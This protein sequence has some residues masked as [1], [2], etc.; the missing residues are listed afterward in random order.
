MNR[1]K[2]NLTCHS[3]SKIF[4]DPVELPCKHSICQEHFSEKKHIK[5]KKIKCGACK[6][7]FEIKEF[8][9]VKLIKNLLDI[10][11]Y[12]N[13]D[14]FKLKNQIIDSFENCN[15][16]HDEFKHNKN[17]FYVDFHSHFQEIKRQIDFQGAKLKE[18]IDEATLELIKKAEQFEYS[19]LQDLNSNNVDFINSTEKISL[20]KGLKEIE[21]KFRN[22]N[23][24]IDSMEKILFDQQKSTIELK[25][26]I[27]EMNLLKD[28]LI[29]TNHFK[30]KLIFNEELLGSLSLNQVPYGAFKSRILNVNM[31]NDLIRLCEFMPKDHW[32][33]LYRA[34][35]DG[36]G[37]KDFHSK[38]DNHT[39]TLTII[40]EKI[41][42]LFLE[43]ILQPP[44]I[45]LINTS[46]TLMPFYLV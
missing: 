32:S 12:L 19:Y 22:S 27:N 24:S 44:G 23:I 2:S 4:K 8:R 10:Q 20:E 5:D 34:S 30:P 38:C 15:K 11:I 28:I 31:E 13:D 45:A 39:N 41:S 43:L 14:E 33:L 36:F 18:K 46:Q 26:K 25:S 7:Y 17:S 21:E 6:E 40:K 35:R 9:I 1:W 3:C 16:V 37:S 29:K 42:L